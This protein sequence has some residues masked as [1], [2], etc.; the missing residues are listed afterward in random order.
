MFG[1][2]KP[3]LHLLWISVAVI[4]AIVGS[5]AGWFAFEGSRAL[6][7]PSSAEAPQKTLELVI[8]FGTSARGIAELMKSEGL[9]VHVGMF[10]AHA[11]WLGVHRNLQAGV[12]VAEPG[13]TKKQMIL[14]LA[15][16]DPTQTELR[17]L[18]GWTV[19]QIFGAMIRNKDIR[20]D[21]G[22]PL[23]DRELARRLE[24]KAT[25][26]EGWVHPESYVV[27]K[28]SSAFEI[29]SRA[30]RI[31]KAFVE[32]QW[33]E[34]NPAVPYKSVQEALIVASIVEK[35]T[36][37]SGDREK[38]AAVFAN[39]IRLG[40]PLQ[41]DPTVIYG[42]GAAFDGNI[43]REHLLRDTPYNTY[44]RKS[45]PPTPISN[46]GRFA[47]SAAMKPADSRALF[48]VSR[49]DGSS[50]FSETLTQ[51]NAAVDKFIRKLTVK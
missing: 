36:Q 11:R 4:G 37:F 46:P 24:I 35:E 23:T 31:Q 22:G 21:I 17:I 13:I 41:A 42:L 43:T 30:V 40:M 2:L 39:R 32:R 20:F 7:R 47:I 8:P 9:D 29:L 51:H 27:P 45:L 34:R 49:G 12:Y 44:T 15:R 6:I 19:R 3:R 25:N 26:I 14:R 50:E 10:L 28:G 16:Q 38:V 1:K 33:A 18:E 5:V 48:F